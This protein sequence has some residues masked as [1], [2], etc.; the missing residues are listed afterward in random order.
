MCLCGVVCLFTEE[1]R[2]DVLINNAGIMCHPQAK[3]EEG[4]E[5][6]F[7]VNYLGRGLL[8]ARKN[9]SSMVFCLVLHLK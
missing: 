9:R 7:G 6:H 5:L 4:I 2:L 1:N 8:H 3:T